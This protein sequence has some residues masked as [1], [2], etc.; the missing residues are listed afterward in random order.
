MYTD[1]V[2]NMVPDFTRVDGVEQRA[3]VCHPNKMKDVAM[4]RNFRRVSLRHVTP[5]AIELIAYF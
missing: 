3:V 4:A 2:R 1:S 5:D